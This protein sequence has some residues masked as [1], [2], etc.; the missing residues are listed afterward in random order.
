LIALAV[1]LLVAAGVLLR[2]SPSAADPAQDA[3]EQEF[4]RLLND[5][6]AQNGE[7]AL[8]LQDDL[9]EAADW[10]ATDM[11]TQNY[12]GGDAY[13]AALNPP[14]PAHCDSLGRMPGARAMA[15]GYPQGVGENIAAGFPSAQSVFDAWS[16]STGHRANM[17]GA[18]YKAIGIGWA[19]NASSYYKCYWVTDFGFYSGPGSPPGPTSSPGN[20]T[21]P[22][23]QAPTPTATPSPVPTQSPTPTP[24][25]TPTPVA[26]L[27]DDINCD[28]RIAPDDAV[29]LIRGD[30]GIDAQSGDCPLVS[31]LIFVNGLLRVWGDTDCTYGVQVLDSIKLLAFLAD[32]PFDDVNA[33][34]P[35][36]GTAF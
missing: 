23:T 6:R 11:A 33:M 34:C 35:A 2:A 31:D 3:Q 16:A 28:G 12:Y 27:W 7:S 26:R 25:P 17:L 9:N 29:R 20:P 10:F 1:A 18:S 15:F 4:L 30:L 36:P 13:C 5:F 8:V 19:C 21:T 32:V 22:P 14:K 24:A